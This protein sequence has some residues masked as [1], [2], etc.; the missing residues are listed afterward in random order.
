MLSG[1]DCTSAFK[2][3]GEVQLAKKLEKNPRY[4][5]AFRY[6]KNK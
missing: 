6:N 4:H 2:E 5:K 1:E 3:K